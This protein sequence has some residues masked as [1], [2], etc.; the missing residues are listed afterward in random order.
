MVMKVEELKTVVNLIAKRGKEEWVMIL[1]TVL[2]VNTMVL[3]NDLVLQ[4]SQWNS[5]P[6]KTTDSLA[7]ITTTIS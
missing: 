7:F 5:V 6:G 4:T 1:N 3:A 2:S